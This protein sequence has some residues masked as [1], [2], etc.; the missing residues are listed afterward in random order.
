M[1]MFDDVMRQMGGLDLNAVA[2]NVGLPEGQID[3]LLHALAAERDEPGDTVEGAAARTGLSPDI[4]RQVLAHLGGEDG[5]AKVGDL[6]GS[7]G[8]LDDLARGFAAKP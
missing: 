5:L 4:I 6:L 7:S 2:T 3:T 1:G 8:G